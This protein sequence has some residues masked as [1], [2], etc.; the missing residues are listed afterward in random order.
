MRPVETRQ[1]LPV[2]EKE[3]ATQAI[4]PF[5]SQ[6]EDQ[7]VPQFDLNTLINDVLADEKRN[8]VSQIST[9]NTNNVMNNIPRSMWSR[10]IT[11]AYPRGINLVCPSCSLNNL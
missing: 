10:G 8:E 11:H 9:T 1:P 4:I 5:E 6:L 2:A 7:Q 3:N